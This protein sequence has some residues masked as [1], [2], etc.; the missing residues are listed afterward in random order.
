MSE[1]DHL[2]KLFDVIAEERR[3]LLGGKSQIPTAPGSGGDA[4]ADS[5]IL[6]VEASYVRV[7]DAIQ[8]CVAAIDA[9]RGRRR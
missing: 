8:V 1:R 3:M 9:E 6:R 7:L 5:E 4:S 2:E